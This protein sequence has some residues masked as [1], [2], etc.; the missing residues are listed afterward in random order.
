MAEQRCHHLN[1]QVVHFSWRLQFFHFYSRD[2]LEIPDID[3]GNGVIQGNG[4]GGDDEVV[5][6]HG[7]PFFGDGGPGDEGGSDEAS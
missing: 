7:S 5:G 4:G 6:A 2:L 1:S 3:R